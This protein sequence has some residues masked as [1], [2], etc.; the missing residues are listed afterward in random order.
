M[1]SSFYDDLNALLERWDYMVVVCV[2][3]KDRYIQKYEKRSCPY[4]SV[5]VVSQ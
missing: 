4:S 5:K 2:F 1:H 3:E